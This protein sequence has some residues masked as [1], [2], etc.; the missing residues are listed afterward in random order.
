MLRGEMDYQIDKHDKIEGLVASDLD[1][2]LCNMYFE[3]VRLPRSNLEIK[4]PFISLNF[5]YCR[6]LAG[7]KEYEVELQFS[8]GILAHPDR[9]N[10][11][12][13]NISFF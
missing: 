13:Q 4:K 1:H 2:W 5:I 8:S 9:I 11:S 7:Q 10:T 3:I 6:Y 12:K